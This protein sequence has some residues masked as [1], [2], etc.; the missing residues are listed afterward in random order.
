MPAAEAQKSFSFTQR[1]EQERE[2]CAK[3]ENEMSKARS[4]YL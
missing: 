1:L 3:E 4:F 2:K